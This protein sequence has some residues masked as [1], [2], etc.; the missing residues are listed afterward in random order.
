MSQYNRV[1][2]RGLSGIRGLNFAY[3][4]NTWGPKT[5]PSMLPANAFTRGY[6]PTPQGLASP[7]TWMEGV[8]GIESAANIL[9]DAQSSLT[10]SGQTLTN[11]SSQVQT[12]LNTAQGYESSTDATIQAKAQACQSEAAGLTAN[13]S[14]VQTSVQNLE[15]NVTTAQANTNEAQADAQVLK[16]Q[17]SAIA[18]QVSTLSSGVSQ[19][20]S[21]V[22]SL[23]K[24]AQSGPSITQAL[25]GTV[26]SSVSTLTWIVGGGLMIYLLAPT[27]IPRLAGGIR[28]AR[29]G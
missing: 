29:K 13:I 23:Q 9:L 27:F 7:L 19:L 11:L 22:A 5:G 21:D 10:N 24:S 14:T 1:I 15:T 26:A 18:T 25:E 16:D 17:A 3:R 8:L 6:I 28:K 20:A 2:Q 12:L 4:L